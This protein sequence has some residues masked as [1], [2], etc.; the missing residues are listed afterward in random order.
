MKKSN[1]FSK[2]NTTNFIC[3]FYSFSKSLSNQED[4]MLY[5]GVDEGMA[6][7]LVNCNP[8]LNAGIAYSEN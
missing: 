8:H 1:I 4:M 7:D 6:Y 2:K 5:F 3:I